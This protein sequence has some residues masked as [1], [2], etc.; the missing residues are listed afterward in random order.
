[1]SD[2]HMLLSDLYLI[3][4]FTVIIMK[5]MKKLT[6][7][8]TM[9]QWL[10]QKP[11]DKQVSSDGYYLKLCNNVKREIEK[12]ELSFLLREYLNNEEIDDLYCFLTAYFEDIISGTNI[13]NTFVKQHM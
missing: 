1:M 11:Y 3:F 8:I 10:K 6:N 13:W 12:L 9:Q 2:P 7:R 4:I 5:D